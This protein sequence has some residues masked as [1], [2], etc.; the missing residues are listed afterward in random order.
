M[1]AILQKYPRA[2]EPPETRPQHR[3]CK[4]AVAKSG[5]DVVTSIWVVP[6]DV[7][8]FHTRRLGSLR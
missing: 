4:K 6:K 1:D 2:S 7:R 8:S 3:C 5:F